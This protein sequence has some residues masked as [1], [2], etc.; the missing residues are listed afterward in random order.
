MGSAALFAR[1]RRHF[2]WR[3]QLSAIPPFQLHELVDRFLAED[4]GRGDLTTNALVGSEVAGRARIEARDAC[5]VAGLDF[6]RACFERVA[7]E[8]PTW[9]AAVAEGDRVS[10]GEVIAKIEG[11]LAAILTAERTALNLLQ[12]ATGIATLTAEFVAAV[13]GTPARIVD[14]RKTAPGLRALDKHAVRVGG[15]HNHRFGLDDGVLIKD[16][17][18]SALGG[19][20]AEAVRRARGRA[21]HGLLIEVEVT[22]L[23]QL[24]DAIA[25]GADAIM[26]DNFSPDLVRAAVE[27]AGGKAI[28]EASGGMTLDNVRPY[29]L[30]GVD[31]ISVGA[32]THSVPA[33]DLALEVES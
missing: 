22:D 5:V 18:L 12:R 26:L 4:I 17:H 14:T 29:A 19:D 3:P 13:D 16:N 6:A 11:G 27:R 7:A 2:R 33:A 20:I 8:P 32:L 10:A 23:D 31:L 25:A 28:L 21:P 15:G 30:A 9:R 24:D 1:M